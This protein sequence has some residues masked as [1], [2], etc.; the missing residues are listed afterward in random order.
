MPAA[1][2]KHTCFLSGKHEGMDFRYRSAM[3]MLLILQ[4]IVLLND[5]CSTGVSAYL[6]W[7][8][9]IPPWIPEIA[10][11]GSAQYLCMDPLKV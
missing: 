6:W 2:L 11:M 1:L 5:N 7:S 10:D 3:R 9:E 4:H 8:F